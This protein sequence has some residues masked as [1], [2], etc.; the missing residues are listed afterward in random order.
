MAA[1]DETFV[2]VEG[3]VIWR[4]LGSSDATRDARREPPPGA[5]VHE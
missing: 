4:R 2:V 5:I 3:Y 1:V